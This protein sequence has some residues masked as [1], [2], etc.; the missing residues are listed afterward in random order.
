MKHPMRM[1]PLALAAGFLLVA[2]CGKQDTDSPRLN[3]TLGDSPAGA[4]VGAGSID[5]GILQDQAAYKPADYE[6]LVERAAAPG[7][8]PVAAGDQG[9]D[10]TAIR[11]VAHDALLSLM[12]LNL[13]GLLD[14]FPEENIAALR[15]DECVSAADGLSDSLN[16]FFG[17][18]QSKAGP[19]APGADLDIAVLTGS[20]ADALIGTISVAVLDEQTATATLDM[21]RFALPDDVRQAIDEAMAAM[22]GGGADAG[23]PNAAD[24]AEAAAGMGGMSPDALLAMAKA[25]SFDIPFRRTDDGWRVDVPIT[26][27]EEHAELLAEGFGIISRIYGELAQRIGAMEPFNPQEMQAIAQQVQMQH[28]GELM[29]WVG[30]AQMAAMSLADSMAAGATDEAD[31]PPGDEPPA[32]TPE[33]EPNNG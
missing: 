7:A 15:A 19:D 5:T 33:D 29:G 6:P 4:P 16:N 14:A 8:A 3:E 17:V 13:A 22:A 18:M 1:L 28:M 10:A 32:D 23:E 24:A 2:G 26:F 21:G 25:I 12:E 20:L 9:E 11:E 31:Q 27:E 30:R